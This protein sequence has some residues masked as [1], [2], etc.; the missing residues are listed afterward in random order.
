[1]GATGERD[2]C[3]VVTGHHGR[4]GLGAT[5]QTYSTYSAS[6]GYE[7]DVDLDVR[8][9][10][11][12]LRRWWWIAVGLPIIT[13][14]IVF[15]VVS[16][17]TPLY[18]A[19]ATLTVTAASA[20]NNSQLDPTRS[21]ALAQTYQE[22]VVTQ[23]VLQPVADRLG[24]DF[25]VDVVRRAVTV[26]SPASRFLLRISAS[27][28]DPE[29]AALIANYVADEFDSYIQQRD[30]DE[31]SEGL[32]GLN[33]LIAEQEQAVAAAQQRLEQ[34]RADGAS[35]A[36]IVQAT[37]DLDDTRQ[38]LRDTQSRSQELRAQGALQQAQV[39]IAARAQQP[40]TAYAPRTVFYTAIGLI[41]G[42]AMA[43]GLIV[44]IEYLD[45]TV[46]PQLNFPRAHRRP[47]VG[48]RPGRRQALPPRQRAAV[49]A[50]SGDIDDGGVDP[51]AA[52]EH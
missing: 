30:E 51:A 21:V 23:E 39:R 19:T 44:V 38:Q 27:D 5:P 16:R 15:F 3:H 8:A 11:G 52:D 46:K 25:T 42:L 37:V 4:L 45:N 34:L 14:G 24:G 17:Q 32:R 26:S 50:D 41:L 49:H 13:A 7:D 22:L 28:A 48:G 29:Q 40:T 43:G 36:A 12:Y 9:L 33:A 18:R 47:V 2:L 31:L 20:G 1:M 6:R 35:E 10:L